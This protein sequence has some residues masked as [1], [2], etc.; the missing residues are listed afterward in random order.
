MRKTEV[1][2]G[3]CPGQISCAARLKGGIAVV[4][5]NK[6]VGFVRFDFPVPSNAHREDVPH[7][8]VGQRHRAW[9]V[10]LICGPGKQIRHE[11]PIGDADLGEAAPGLAVPLHSIAPVAVMVRRFKSVRFDGWARTRAVSGLGKL[12]LDCNTARSFDENVQRRWPGFAERR[13]RM[14]ERQPTLHGFVEEGRV[15]ILGGQVLKSIQ[16][17]EHS[18]IRED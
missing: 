18:E 12:D 6:C 7:K 9:R 14:L 16:P 17:V 11:I 10:I 2:V 1:L 8:L 13:H 3:G 15:A 5:N 4:I